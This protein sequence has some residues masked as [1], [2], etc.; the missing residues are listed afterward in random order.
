MRGISVLLVAAMALAVSTAAAQG[1]V[2]WQRADIP[3]SPTVSLDTLGPV[4]K[5]PGAP[6][7]VFARLRALYRQ[8]GVRPEVDDS[9]RGRI[10]SLEIIRTQQFAGGWMSRI[11]ECGRAP[12]GGPLADNARVQLSIVTFVGA[13]DGDSTSVRTG[14]VGTARSNDG[15]SLSTA[16]CASRGYVELW[17]R[18]QLGGT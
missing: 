7:A 10:G 4:A 18:R 11:V 5:V 13:A 9:A 8:L 17:L 2:T 6:G 14:L 12:S 3:H 16:T 15:S 1:V